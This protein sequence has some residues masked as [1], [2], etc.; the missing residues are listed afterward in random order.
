MGSGRL[1][2]LRGNRARYVES[3]VEYCPYAIYPA[4]GGPPFT[5]WSAKQI[6]DL[7]ARPREPRPKALPK[8]RTLEE[9]RAFM[10]ESKKKQKEHQDFILAIREKLDA[11]DAA[12]SYKTTPMAVE[13]SPAAASTPPE[14]FKAAR[15]RPELASTIPRA[16]EIQHLISKRA[17]EETLERHVVKS[18]R[19]QE[20]TDFQRTEVIGDDHMNYQPEEELPPSAPQASFKLAAVVQTPLSSSQAQP[21]TSGLSAKA[22]G[23]RPMLD[24]AVP[25]AA[26]MQEPKDSRMQSPPDEAAVENGPIEADEQGG[27]MELEH[28]STGWSRRNSAPARIN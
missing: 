9:H 1:V 12:A 10:A 23:K 21:G 14:T 17:A 28:V 2:D 7:L 26:E 6:D 13:S 22:L 16:G 4:R 8:V 15:D 20:P 24:P 11:R 19:C 25:T 5:R 27:S 18:P 3:S